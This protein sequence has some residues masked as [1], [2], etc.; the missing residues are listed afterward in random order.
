MIILSKN[1]FDKTI[2]LIENNV[3]TVPT[4]AYSV[5]NNYMSGVVYAD[6]KNPETILIGTESGIYFV[7][8]KENNQEFNEFLCELYNQ[9]KNK[10]LR[11]TL[12]SSNEYWDRII[13]ELFKD[14]LKQI[15]RY[16]YI[17]DK[18]QSH[19]KKL[20][21]N[22]YS[23][24]KISEELIASSSEFNE[25]YYNEYW[26]SVAN[27]TAKGF[28]YCMLHRGEVICE[29]TSIFASLQFSEIDIETHK[30]Y[31]GQ[32]LGLIVAKAFINHCLEN[33]IKPRWD[34]DIS[35][36]SSI[37]LAEKLGFDNPS[38]YS[39]FVKNV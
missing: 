5:L 1:D 27:F 26:G 10:E 16:S 22:E 9:R 21:A 35:N 32:G 33:G 20:I 18:K 19:D 14:N 39:I 7:A 2:N 37:R 11:F 3:K 36:A 6:S 31:R 38:E 8:G 23:I 28:G 4:F 30:D 24:R 29:C 34:C 12:F 15:N 25:D 13:H 17:Y